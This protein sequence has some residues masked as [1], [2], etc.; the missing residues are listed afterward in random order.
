MSEPLVE[1]LPE[2]EHDPKL[3]SLSINKDT[4]KRIFDSM[5]VGIALLDDSL[6]ICSYNRVFG[7]YLRR[8]TRLDSGEILGTTLTDHLS[9]KDNK[10][11][12]FKQRFDRAIVSGEPSRLNNLEMKFAHGDSEYETCWEVYI[13]PL[14]IRENQESLALLIVNDTM[15]Q[16]KKEDEIKRSEK[17][18]RAIF[19]ATG[20]A[21][22]V[23]E[24]DTVISMMNSECEKLWGFTREEVEGK[25]SWREFVA[26]QDDLDR[27]NEY[28]ISRR[29][30]PSLAPSEY[31]FKFID[32]AGFRK[33][34]LVTIG[35]VPDTRQHVASMLDMTNYKDIEERLRQSNDQ[36]RALATHLQS[37]REEE[38]GMLAREIHDE[39]G[40]SLT[41][42]K[43]DL[44][45]LAKRLDGDNL[46]AV[47][48][49]IDFVD[50]NTEYVQGLAKRLK[51]LILD[52]L[53]LISA[54]EWLI[55]DFQELL[56]I[57]CDYSTN[58]SDIDMDP[59]LATA[60]F[61]ILQEA[62]T[63]VAR[64]AEATNIE[65]VLNKDG[66][67]ITLKV[68]DDGKGLDYE[69]I[70]QKHCMGLMG[71]RERAALFGGEAAIEGKEG[72]GTT[73]MVKMPIS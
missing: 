26:C 51:P 45:R 13:L 59:K 62:L 1:F 60:L 73:V 20:T 30:D 42:L 21:S 17:L 48:R 31:Q 14:V 67:H 57:E 18:Y 33:D 6:S 40:Q 23:I 49:M 44:S 46:Q 15:M 65:V 4:I 2:Q 3:Q 34:V 43:I 5:P 47:E 10:M 55:S 50:E 66:E 24:N 61:R 53:G 52:D 22:V 19:E 11:G 72:E 39:L 68:S 12:S 35:V 29:V 64:H 9:D 7:D 58:I 70:E 54:A 28:H 56:G 32:K 36:L 8:Y 16:K 41:K 71:I 37:V 27:M 38:R 69:K 63:N 25:K